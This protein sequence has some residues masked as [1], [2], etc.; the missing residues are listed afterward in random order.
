MGGDVDEAV[1]RMVQAELEAEG[2]DS[3]LP[4]GHFINLAVQVKHIAGLRTR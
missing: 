3:K 2:D 4:A 1:R